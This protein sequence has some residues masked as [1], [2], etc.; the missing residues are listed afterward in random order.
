MILTSIKIELFIYCKALFTCLFITIKNMGG[1]KDKSIIP[2]YPVG[3]TGDS[4][5]VSI[6]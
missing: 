4:S 6:N 1:M 3:I 5:E 2:G